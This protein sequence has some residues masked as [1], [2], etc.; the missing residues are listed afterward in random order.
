M[1]ATNP[2]VSL[3]LTHVLYDETSTVS[4][5]L[6]LLT[7]SPILINPAYAVLAVQT[8]ELFFM[9]MWAGQMLCEASN[10]VLKNLVR[11]QRP[12]DDLGDGYGFPSSHS[13]WM[14]YFSTFLICHILC[15]HRFVSTGWH[16]VDLLW[17]TLVLT[18]LV[19][20]A[21]AVAFSRYYLGYH[22]AH[23]VIWGTVIGMLFG[24]F[25]YFTLEI[26]PDRYPQSGLGRFR[27][28]VLSNPL[29]VWLRV[30]DGWAVWGD[31]GTE[32]QWLQWRAEWERK[33]KTRRSELGSKTD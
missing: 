4:S 25:Y 10:W 1:A 24:T 27:T 30:R 7:L 17:K 11:Q 9:E 15:R 3:D 18:G 22:T 33:L 12:N 21:G 29:S 26:I 23:Q 6:A 8:R 28:W 14:G 13:Q 31:S 5:V 16:A 32:A 2:R 20:W 19:T